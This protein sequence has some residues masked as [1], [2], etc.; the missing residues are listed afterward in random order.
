MGTETRWNAKKS[1]A[2]LAIQAKFAVA[3]QEIEADASIDC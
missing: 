2:A 3:D 1:R